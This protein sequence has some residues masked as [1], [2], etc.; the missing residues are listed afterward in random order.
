MYGWNYSGKTTLSRIFSYLDKN[1]VIED[2]YKDVEFEFELNDRRKVDHTNRTT[3]SMSIRIFNSDFIRNNLHFDTDSKIQSIKF[4]V[5]EVANIHFQIGIIDQ[6]IQ[7]A[8]DIIQSNSQY[9][10]AYNNFDNKLFTDLA[11]EIS[12][13]FQ[14]RNFNKTNVKYIINQFGNTSLN[15]Y[16]IPQNEYDGIRTNA[17]SPNAGSIID[18]SIKPILIYEK[19]LYATQEL[20][21][22]SP[23]EGIKDEIL[24][25]N[26]SLY[27]WVKDGLNIYNN[28]EI[29]KCAFCGAD[30]SNGERILY[31][32]A[33]YSNEASR[34]KDAI[35]SLIIEIEQE[36]NSAKSLR[37]AYISEND[38]ALN[39]R[40]H[41]VSLKKSYEVLCTNYIGLLNKLIDA[42]RS[43]ENKS[44]FIPVTIEPFDSTP[45][46]NLVSWIDDLQKV[47]IESN[48]VIANFDAIR[49]DSR[50]KLRKHIIAQFLVDKEYKKCL[51]L[52]KI[53]EKG[54]EKLQRAIKIK[55]IERE[56]R[57]TT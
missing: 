38:I 26:T 44:L 32:N 30:I 52:K 4:A 5:G 56:S 19:L 3:S 25:N 47:L 14:E 16:I 29:K 28:I 41:F 55:E 8:K 2:E 50:D 27:N 43:K 35:S 15:N 22:T 17:L 12:N 33:F 54:I 42:L 36:I 53:E 31:L 51:R 49:S 11:R 6:Y 18:S 34:V 24:S 40:E 1:T 37:W 10:G 21:K 39:V 57:C 45:Y 9:I 20:L 13:L 23:A 48:N 46:T 7:K